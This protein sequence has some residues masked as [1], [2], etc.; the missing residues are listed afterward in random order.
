MAR[1]RAA[2]FQPRADYFGRPFDDGI[3]RGLLDAGYDVDVYAPDWGEPQD[4]Y[5]NAVHRLDVEYRRG[6]LLR[7]V[8]RARWRRYDLF[9]GN[10]DLGTACAA[11]LALAARRPFVNAV[12]EIYVGGYEGPALGWWKS[13]ARWGEGRASFTIITDLCRA[14]LQ[15]GYAGLGSRH[16]FLQ[17][18]S[19]FSEAYT[20][21]GRDT[22]RAGLGIQQ[23]EFVVALAGAL[24]PGNGADWVFRE[25]DALGGRLLIQ[26]GVRAEPVLEALSERLVREGRATLLSDRVSYHRAA[27]LTMAADASLAL[28]RSPKPQF[29][30][31]GVSSQKVCV[32]LWLGIPL[33]ATRQPSFDFIERFGCGVL[34]DGEEQLAAAVAKIKSDPQPYSAGARRAVE[35]YVQ[36]GLRRTHL[37]EAFAAI[38]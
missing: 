3:I 32:S 13:A 25:I 16:R 37:A 19:C 17:Y 28:Y 30:A 26:P 35:E 24:T 23:N 7:N 4:V 38:R 1:R 11:V 20:G 29:Q 22:V 36:P 33:V 21:P 2:Y 6:W 5:P 8:G 14:S 10:P 9:L 18:P 27:E 34:I 15:R 31:M 12:D